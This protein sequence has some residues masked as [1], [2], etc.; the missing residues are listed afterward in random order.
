MMQKLTV[1]LLVFAFFSGNA[2]TPLLQKDAR[3]L[4]TPA[5]NIPDTV[6]INTPVAISNVSSGASSYYWNFC[7]ASLNTNPIATTIGN[8]GSLQSPVF[9]DYAF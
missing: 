4:V 2:Q 7:I 9:I 5:F 8:P 1:L 3:I 6:C